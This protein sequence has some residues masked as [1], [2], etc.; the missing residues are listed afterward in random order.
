MWINQRHITTSSYPLEMIMNL[1]ANVLCVSARNMKNILVFL[2]AAL[3]I[4]CSEPKRKVSN[5]NDEPERNVSR[6][7]PKWKTREFERKEKVKYLMQQLNDDSQDGRNV[8]FAELRDK[9][10]RRRDIAELKEEISHNAK[11]EDQSL[12]WELLFLNIESKWRLP[13]NVW[14]SDLFKCATIWGKE[15]EDL[16]CEAKVSY[17]PDDGLRLTIPF[18][19]EYSTEVINLIL[20]MEPKI[21][22]VEGGEQKSIIGNTY[23]A[24]LLELTN[25]IEIIGVKDKK[26]KEIVPQNQAD[27]DSDIATPS[28]H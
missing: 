3:L 7:E 21:L 13:N 20:D 10:I 25:D 17:G 15:I 24:E 27:R 19:S 2:L 6:A 23:L 22:I 1:A 28:N 8:S 14:I 12:L 26:I 18:Q 5:G 11:S 9:Y 4:G 16:G